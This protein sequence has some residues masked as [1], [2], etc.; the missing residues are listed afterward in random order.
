M[1]TMN[2]L[3]QRYHAGYLSDEPMS[4]YEKLKSTRHK[5]NP[6]KNR[7]VQLK[8]ARVER[9]KVHGAREYQKIQE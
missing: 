4:R 5:T 1:L 7:T 3:T 2:N 8:K 9:L 6:E